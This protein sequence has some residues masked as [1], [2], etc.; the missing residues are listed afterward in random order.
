MQTFKRC[1]ECGLRIR[2]NDQ[3]RHE[4]GYHHKA[5]METLKAAAL[6]AVK[7]ANQR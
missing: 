2:C 3:K 4:K 6:A 7:K 1:Q 5:R